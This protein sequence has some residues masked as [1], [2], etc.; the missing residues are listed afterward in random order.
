MIPGGN[1][2][3]QA[4]SI[5]GQQQFGLKKFVRREI[6]DIGNDI[7]QYDCEVPVS[8]S[9]QPV[10]R[11]VYNSQG[12]DRKRNYITVYSSDPVVGVGRDSSGDIVKYDGR[13]FQVMSENDWSSQDG[14]A[15]VL[16]VE[17][18]RDRG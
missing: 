6:N 4:L 13:T 10:P 17:I 12:L 2:L 3:N 9:V 1:L 11:S 14:W 8:G 18:A 16:C 5:I 7:P 15:G